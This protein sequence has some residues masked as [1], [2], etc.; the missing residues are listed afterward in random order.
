MVIKTEVERQK[1]ED[2]IINLESTI[3]TEKATIKNENIKKQK[4]ED[5]EAIVT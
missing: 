4:A 2:T 5:D 1:I 3:A